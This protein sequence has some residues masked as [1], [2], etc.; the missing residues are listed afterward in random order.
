MMFGQLFSESDS[1]RCIWSISKFFF[2]I[3]VYF[4]NF[5]GIWLTYQVVLASGV[6]KGN[7][8][9]IYIYPLFLRFFSYIDQHRV[10]GRFLCAIQQVPVTYSFVY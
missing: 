9:Y 1:S 3:F 7:Q 10:L 4:K 5:I 6:R 8:F 2:V